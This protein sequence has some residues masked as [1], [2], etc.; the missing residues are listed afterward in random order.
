MDVV[1]P[2][3]PPE[4]LESDLVLFNLLEMHWRRRRMR[5]MAA[6]IASAIIGATLGA[7]LALTILLWINNV[8]ALS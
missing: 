8:F 4:V 6:K 5:D 7:V 2:R 1:E 3:L